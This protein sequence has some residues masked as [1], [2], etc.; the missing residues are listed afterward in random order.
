MNPPEEK[1]FGLTTTS[2]G[3]LIRRMDQR[4]ELVNR[5]MEEIQAKQTVCDDNYNAALTTIKITH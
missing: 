3:G 2:S 5:L 1:P 4:L